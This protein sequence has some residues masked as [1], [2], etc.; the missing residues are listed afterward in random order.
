MNTITK[1]M[2]MDINNISIN[3]SDWEELEEK[4]L[5][6]IYEE[7]GAGG[8]KE[9]AIKKEDIEEHIEPL[10]L[11]ERID[12][13]A[14]AHAMQTTILMTSDPSLMQEKTETMSTIIHSSIDDLR[15]CLPKDMNFTDEETENLKVFIVNV[16]SL[17]RILILVMETI[18]SNTEEISSP[19]VEIGERI[20]QSYSKKTKELCTKKNLCCC[21]KH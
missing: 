3:K 18:L 6:K 17:I 14:W 5:N 19:S 1:E 10:S 13:F 20:I 4:L 2:L 9:N 15:K 11:D 16:I 7:T 21:E 12:L 8:T